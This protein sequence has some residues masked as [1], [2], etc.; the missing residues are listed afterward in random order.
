MSRRALSTIE[1]EIDR[2]VHLA[3]DEADAKIAAALGPASSCDDCRADWGGHFL[4]CRYKRTKAQLVHEIHRL[5][6]E[7]AS[8]GAE[9]VEHP[10]QPTHPESYCHRCNGPNVSWAAPS[11][12]WNQ[13]MR[14]GDINGPW[15][16]DEI[17][18][19]TCFAVLAEEAGAAANWRL[20]ADVVDADLQ[21]VTPSGRV[22]DEHEFRWIDAIPEPGEQA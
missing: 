18:C 1:A 19:P 21:T 17:I 8:P 11:P 6:A 10:G 14:G 12:L 13:V 4:G 3:M 5:L 20:V 22:W 2:K 7:K 15:L 16:Y 9:H